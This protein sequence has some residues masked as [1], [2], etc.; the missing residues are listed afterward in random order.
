MGLSLRAA[1]RRGHMGVVTSRQRY[2]NPLVD[3]DEVRLANPKKTKSTVSQSG[4]VIS[5]TTEENFA[6]SSANM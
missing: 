2:V 1:D 3:W 4:Q 6:R 5:N